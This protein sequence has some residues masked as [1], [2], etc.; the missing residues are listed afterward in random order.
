MSKLSEL[1]S[2]QIDQIVRKVVQQLLAMTGTQAKSKLPRETQSSSTSVRLTER[3]ITMDT[4]SKIG[5]EIKQISVVSC[6]VITPAV[7]DE[8]RNKKIELVLE[9]GAAEE[10]L[11]SKL[12]II[13]VG[14]LQPGAHWQQAGNVS[15]IADETSAVALAAGQIGSGKQTVILSN[16]PFLIA[17]EA[18]RNTKGQAAVVDSLGQLQEIKQQIQANLLAINPDRF[19]TMETIRLINMIK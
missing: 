4:I 1:N 15:V 16:Q 3:L 5:S 13:S 9:K 18:N 2:S 11:C 6:A 19:N 12:S 17:C 14:T 7:K 8:L 10:I